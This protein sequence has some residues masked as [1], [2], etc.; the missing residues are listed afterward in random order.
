MLFFREEK[1]KQEKVKEGRED[2]SGKNR[3][4]SAGKGQTDKRSTLNATKLEEE[5]RKKVTKNE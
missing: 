5:R 2:C 4:E 3:T 1:R